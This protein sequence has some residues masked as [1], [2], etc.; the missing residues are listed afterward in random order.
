MKM[1]LQQKLPEYMQPK[2]L[3]FVASFPLNA[4]GKINKEALLTLLQS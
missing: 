1:E 2:D 3:I 4:N